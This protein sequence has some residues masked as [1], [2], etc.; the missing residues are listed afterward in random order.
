MRLKKKYKKFSKLNFIIKD[1][2]IRLLKF[3]RT[4]WKKIQQLFLSKKYFTRRKVFWS[5]KTLLYTKRWSR[6]KLKYL[7][8]VRLKNHFDCLFD[9]VF[10]FLFFKNLKYLNKKMDK[11]LEYSIYIMKPEFRIDVL[12]WRLNFFSC[13]YHS[14]QNISTKKITVNGKNTY[15][16]YFLKKGDIIY[17]DN[18][19]YHIHSHFKH[20]LSKKSNTL[21]IFTFI[22]IDYYTNTI[23]ILKNY[24]E[25]TEN[26]IR[27]YVS[28]YIDVAKFKTF[29]E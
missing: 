13:C 17:V 22:E 25:L 7:T 29:I 9:Q 5:S 8:G 23:I 14:K 2:P 26:D 6:C 12:L 20:L 21:R 16:N 1:F 19:T 4:K 28:N 11:I 3:H 10:S 15:S 24:D 27:L 18:S